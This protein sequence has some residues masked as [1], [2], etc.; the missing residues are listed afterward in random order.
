MRKKIVAGNWKM[1]LSIEK[2]LELTSEI[3]GMVRDEVDTHI[4]VVICPTHLH[5]SP[6]KGLLKRDS[7][8]KLGAQNCHFEESGAFTGEISPSTLREL[9]C[10]YVIIGHS[11]RRQYF[12]ED[13]GLLRKKLE[14]VLNE[15]M[16]PIYC[17]GER[18]EDRESGKEKEVV[19]QQITE[20]LQGL[21]TS[22]ILRTVIAY[23]PVWAIGTGKTA[24]SEQAQEMHAYIRSLVAEFYGQEVANQISIL[25]GGSVKAGNAG[26]LFA[27]PDIDGGLI[28]GAALESRS[29]TNIAKSF[30]GE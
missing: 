10:S 16:S 3:K 2:G 1:N 17:C 21:E 15:H 9:E 11:E 19:K 8:I 29:F 25:Y 7:M 13:H 22:Q 23:E 28:G 26:E 14:A 18:L 27:Q 20:V 12:H 24:S 6:V 30:S 4:E 5:L